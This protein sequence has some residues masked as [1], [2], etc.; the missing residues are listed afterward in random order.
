MALLCK[1][2]NREVESQTQTKEWKEKEHVHTFG[3]SKQAGQFSA[4]TGN[5]TCNGKTRSKEKLF[6]QLET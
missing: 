1:T 2:T 6:S 4:I 5:F 3:D